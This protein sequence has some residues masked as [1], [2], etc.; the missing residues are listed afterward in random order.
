MKREIKYRVIG[1]GGSLMEVKSLLFNT[2][3]GLIAVTD[4]G[5][6]RISDGG[7][8]LMEYTGMKDKN[9]KEIYEGDIVKLFID[10]DPYLYEIIWEEEHQRFGLVEADGTIEHDSWA[11]TSNNDFEVIGNIYENPNL[12][13]DGK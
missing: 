3:V 1:Y 2:S 7:V 4:E 6:Y 5:D 13:N 10:G 12:L 11:Y 8:Y 9:G